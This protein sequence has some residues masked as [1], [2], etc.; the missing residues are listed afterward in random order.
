LTARGSGSYRSS[1]RHPSRH[2]SLA[3]AIVA[4]VWILACGESAPPPPPPPEVLVVPAV[5]RDVPMISEWLGT[6]QGSVDAEIRSQVAGYLVS[7]DYQEGQRVK[8]GDLLF[9]IDPRTFRAAL[10]QARGD[11]GRAQAELEIARLD[12]DRYTPLV[13]E[14][15]VSRQEYDNAVQRKR[16]GE[17]LVQTARAAAEN[18]EIQLSFTEI[19]SPIDGI[20]GIALAQLGDFVGPS[21]PGPLTSVSQLDPIRVAFP[22]SEQEYLHFAPR[23]NK[24]LDDQSFREDALQIVLADGTIYPHLGTAFPAGRE[25]DPR[26]GTITLKGVFPNPQQVLRPGLY[27]RVRVETDIRPGAIVVPQR[28]L[29][30]LQG[31]SQVAVVKADDTIELR[32]V[33]KGAAWGTLQVV[34]TGL[35]AGDRVVVEGFQKVRPGM[36][37]VAKDAPPA[38]A[39]APPSDGPPP[40]TVRDP[41]PS[42]PAPAPAPMPTPTPAPAQ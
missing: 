4:F 10:D 41:A 42:V 26:T 15:A 18:A 39:G 12:V 6:T 38:L 29:Q 13:K 37:V 8:K 19:R 30:D 1:V 34:E 25:I 5:A 31:S 20:V 32:A 36:T 16:S 24:A 35:A 3:A 2:R 23:F 14:G 17:A 40:S 27:A 28:A 11:L 33:K 9:R 7:R 21:D 22:L